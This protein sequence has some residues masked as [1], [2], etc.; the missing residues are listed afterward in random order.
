MTER[1]R[2]V[3][4]L[5][6]RYYDRF[7]VAE[8]I[9][10]DPLQFPHAYN[11][12]ADIEV[13]GFVAASMAFGRVTA[14]APVVERLLGVLGPSPA[15]TLQ[16]LHGG[17]TE[18]REVADDA[19]REAAGR[20]Y[21]WLE[22][23]D[24]E[25]LLRAVASVLAEHGTL[26]EAFAVWDDGGPDTWVA[27]GGFLDDL[28]ERARE[29]HPDPEG[30]S[31]A[32]AFLFPSTKRTAACKRQHLFLR[33]MA[34][35]DDR[36][37]DLGIWTSLDPARLVMPC[38]THTARIGHALGLCSSPKPGRRTADQLTA[39]MR[40]M[41]AADPVRYDFALCHLGISGGCRAQPLPVCDTCTL[42]PGCRWA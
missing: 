17:I 18:V 9:P 37:A 30:R 13:A 41:H 40:E 4:P 10:R 24:I 5:L 35:P 25:A 33:W 15:A 3:L 16:S 36:G 34:R 26:E 12:P 38:D 6:D 42:Q 7:D 31:R 28:R 1:A 14:F 32:L 2:R 21:R 11:D 29:A 8:H 39:A 22:C 19:V 23:M 27:L 20:K